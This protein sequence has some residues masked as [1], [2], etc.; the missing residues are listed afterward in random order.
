[1]KRIAIIPARAG[2]KGVPDK[3]I[4]DVCGKPLMVWT[5][6]N[7]VKSGLFEHVIVSTDSE[8]YA[9]IAQDAG[10]EVVMR[11]PELATDTAITYGVIKHVLETRELLDAD[12]FMLLQVT[13]IM[14]TKQQI[15]EAAELFEKNMHRDD[16]DY[17]V[18]VR[19]AD[20]G[21][22]FEIDDGTLKNFDLSLAQTRR[23]DIKPKYRPNG[24]IYISR[25]KKYI[26]SGHFYGPTSLA[27]IM[28]A[29]TSVD[30]DEWIDFELAKVLMQKR[31]EG[32][33]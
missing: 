22:E 18:S 12:W 13:S 9:K 24:A 26:E 23:Q 6:D 27:Y 33:I 20:R 15:I 8:K 29:V 5:I 19:E 2:S 1:M 32:E 10:A 25:P 3:N 21:S 14:R 17:V 11:P 30:I 31:I 16:V 4:L 7:A 28:D